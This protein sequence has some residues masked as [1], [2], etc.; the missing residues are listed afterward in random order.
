MKFD[1]KKLLFILCGVCAFVLGM[2]QL[3]EPDIWWQLTAGKWMLEHGAIT[4]TDMFSYTMAGHPWI[5]VKWLYEV[6]IAAME[7]LFGPECVLLLQSLVNVTIVYLLIRTVKYYTQRAKEQIPSFAIALSVLLFLIVSEYRMAG[8]P[9]MISHLLC[10]LY[11]LLLWRDPEMNWKSIAWLIPLQCLWANMH[12]GYPVGIV[13]AG[14]AV[15]G[16]LVSYLITKE[17]SALQQTLRMLLIFAACVLIILANP[18]GI[19]LWKQPFEIYRQVWANKYTTELFSYKDAEYWTVQAKL[20]IGIT[21]LVFLYWIM[22][23]LSSAKT[24]QQKTFFTPLITTY[25]ILLPLFT[26]LSLTANRNIPF[27]EIVMLP[28]IAASLVWLAKTIGLSKAGFYQKL[29]GNAGYIGVG[30]IVIFYI[31]IVSDKFYKLTDSPNRYGIHVSMLHNPTG[32]ANFIKEHDI[33]GTGFSDYFVSSYMLWDRY[34]DFKSYIDLRDLDVFPVKFFDDYFSMYNRVE[35][36]D[37]LDHIYNFNYVL[38]S[39][40]QL[41][42]LQYKL[43]WKEG[44]NMI[45][46]DPV[47]VLFLKSNAANKPLNDNLSIQKLFSWPPAIEDPAW[48]GL[49]TK[50]LNPFVS[51]A[52][53]DGSLQAIYAARFYNQV[54]NYPQ[55]VQQLQPQMGMLEDNAEAN[56]EMGNTLMQFANALPPGAEKNRKTDSA[57]IYLQRAEELGGE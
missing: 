23:V 54:K 32:A 27:A 40:S 28:S 38:L 48:A 8:R 19:Q 57:N 21:V 47:C 24:K 20:H 35:K 52:R 56:R 34:P 50:A 9:E 41:A 22:Q 53:E 30:L 29:E 11:L 26:Y 25:L 4:H 6:L 36:F 42:N 15:A 33:K 46:V 7:K 43:Y 3:R 51:Y 5:N 1:L 10:T 16:S 39:T 12:E 55:A 31:S 44:Y 17:K 2:K 18:N 13:I 49:L 37:S 45:Y 14:T